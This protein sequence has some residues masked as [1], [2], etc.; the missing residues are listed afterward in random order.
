MNIAMSEQKINDERYIVVT[1]QGRITA[2]H[3]P[4]LREQ[5]LLFVAQGVKHFV[6]DLSQVEFM[7]SAGLA[8]FVSLLKQAQREGGEA[9]MILPKSEAAQRI[10]RL[11]RFDK[12]F[13]IA[14]TVEA[15]LQIED[16]RR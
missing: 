2:L 8:T 13:P 1:L 9:K 3:A 4:T 5:F 15:A 11:T 6:L 10:L 16:I 12:I 7:D 14:E